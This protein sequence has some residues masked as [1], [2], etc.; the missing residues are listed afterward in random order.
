VDDW[1]NLGRFVLK[2]EKAFNEAAGFTNKDDRLPEFFDEPVPPHNVVWDFTGEELDRVNNS[3]NLAYVVNGQ[4]QSPEYQ[5][6]A[7]K[8]FG[9]FIPMDDSKYGVFPKLH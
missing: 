3:A 9:T 1:F 2:T 5:L 6:T 8:Y 7:E 4:V